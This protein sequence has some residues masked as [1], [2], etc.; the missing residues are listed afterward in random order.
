MPTRNDLVVRTDGLGRR[1]MRV[2][3]VEEIID[4]A[5]G[6]SQMYVTRAVVFGR[7]IP[8]YAGR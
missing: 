4:D 8:L 7:V 1:L 2:I 3:R 6:G 5:D